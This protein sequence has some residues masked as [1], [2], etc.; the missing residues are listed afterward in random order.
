MARRG[1]ESLRTLRGS[2][3]LLPGKKPHRFADDADSGF[4]EKM[5]GPSPCNRSGPE[6]EVQRFERPRRL[7]QA[8]HRSGA[9]GIG[10]GSK[11][12]E[13]TLDLAEFDLQ[14]RTQ[15]ARELPIVSTKSGA[16]NEADAEVA[17]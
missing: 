9:S 7:E 13:Q 6:C 16:D 11:P 3:V 14:S 4:Q 15:T 17:T 5:V 1:G 8:R 10:G 12:L 2:R